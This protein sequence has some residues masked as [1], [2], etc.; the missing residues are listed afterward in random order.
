MTIERVELGPD[1]NLRD[2]LKRV[3]E[4][5]MPRLIEE[6]GEALAVV[7]SPESFEGAYLPKSKRM[8]QQMLSLA[9]VWSDLDADQLIE[10]IYRR[11]HEAPPSSPVGA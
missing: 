1:T 2:V 6:D 11:R 5:K 4:D 8:K 3:R 9:G 7:V 10:E